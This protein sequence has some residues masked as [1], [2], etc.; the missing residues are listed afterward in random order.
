[1][2][3]DAATPGNAP[4]LVRAAGWLSL[5]A[6]AINGMVGA[7]IFALPAIVTQLLGPVSPFA[8]LV[9]GGAVLL[10][11]LCFAEAGSMFERSGGPYVYARAAFGP[12][13]GFEV[14]W[15]FVLTR[16]TAAAAISN[17]FTAYLGYFWPATASGTGRF[18]SIT[19]LL[20][21]LTLINCRGVRPGVW[22]INILTIG[23][24]LPLFVFCVAGLF[25]LDPHSYSFTTMPNLSSLQQGSLLLLFAFGGFEMAS[26]PSEEVIRPKKTLP[27]A[28]ISS[29]SLVVVLYLLIQVVAMGTLPELAS[30]KTPLTSAALN[31][32]GP[33]GAALLTLGAVLSTTGTNSASILVGPRMLYALAEG[34]QLPPFLA[35][36]HARF[37]TPIAAIV[38]FAL[39]TWALAV[40]GTFGQLAAVSALARLLFYATTCLAVPVLRRKMPDTHRQ[41]TLPGGAVIPV[42]AVLVCI[43]LLLGSTLSQGLMM[44]AALAAGV[45]LYVLFARGGDQAAE[46]EI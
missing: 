39:A 42:L 8:Y 3:A 7:G 21:I 43:W 28:L 5:T 30:S 15:L 19:L 31:F 27:L 41:L 12:L 32:L 18:F 37:R 16:L 6:I 38:L 40:S 34:G 22:A 13:V 17:T 24:L 23:K 33:M 14:G 36:I 2:A 4:K 26:V 35:R 29:V 44:G 25:F 20:L 11:A 45:L 46:P 10:I 1:M 9:A